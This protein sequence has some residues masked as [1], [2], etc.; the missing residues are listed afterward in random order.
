MLKLS[1]LLIAFLF[2]LKASAQFKIR[3]AIPFSGVSQPEE[4]NKG[5]PF[6]KRV[7]SKRI[8]TSSLS[9]KELNQLSVSIV[10][11]PVTTTA[12]VTVAQLVDKEFSITEFLLLTINNQTLFK[13]SLVMQNEITIDVSQIPAGIYFV[14][15]ILTD[16]QNNKQMLFQ[17]LIKL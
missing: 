1:F 12:K 16:K 11:N 15:M 10:P 3:G 5:K 7:S 13:K 14:K 8:Y 17:K 4:L 2:S 9:S 6:I